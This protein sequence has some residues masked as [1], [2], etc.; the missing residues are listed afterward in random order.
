MSCHPIQGVP[1]SPWIDFRFHCTLCTGNG[2]MDH[3]VIGDLNSAAEH[4]VTSSG[5]AL[6][7][8]HFLWKVFSNR[9]HLSGG[10]ED[11][12]HEWSLHS[13]EE[14]GLVRSDRSDWIVYP[15]LHSSSAIL[16]P[17][18]TQKP[19]HLHQRI[20]ASYGHCLSYILKVRKSIKQLPVILYPLLINVSTRQLLNNHLVI[21]WFISN[22]SNRN[23]TKTP[24]WKWCMYKRSK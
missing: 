22:N 21:I 23:E 12:G 5:P 20:A 6:G 16:F 13:G 3:E 14:A 18:N 24:S 10:C 7:L 4:L 9:H 17:L 2:W 1:R 8:S 15:W 19:L 11:P